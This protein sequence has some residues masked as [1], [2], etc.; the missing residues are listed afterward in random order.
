MIETVKHQWVK[1][2]LSISKIQCAIL[3]KGQVI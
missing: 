1:K 2:R 3:V